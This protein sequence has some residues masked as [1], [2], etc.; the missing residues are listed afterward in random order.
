MYPEAAPS[1][2][3]E[4]TTRPPSRIHPARDP[5]APSKGSNA[6]R[7]W[8]RLREQVRTEQ[9]RRGLDRA[10][11]ARVLGLAASTLGKTL[12]HRT[13]PSRPITDRLTRFV[14]DLGATP[15]AKGV[16]TAGPGEDGAGPS[17]PPTPSPRQENGQGT[18]GVGG[19]DPIQELAKRLRRKRRPLPLTSTSL[20]AS[21]GVEPDELD[22]AIHGKPVPPQARLRLEA[23]AA[24]G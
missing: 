24:A 3:A 13:A 1:R 10:E 7:D 16:Q 14:A 12:N 19:E 9:A 4:R 20:A 23:W 17:R 15:V 18:E 2:L 21:I 5:G 8:L 22:N 6:D 11:L